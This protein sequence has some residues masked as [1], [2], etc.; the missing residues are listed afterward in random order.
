MGVVMLL[1]TTVSIQIA[2]KYLFRICLPLN[3]PS[4]SSRMIPQ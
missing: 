3:D 4:H 2:A 1:S